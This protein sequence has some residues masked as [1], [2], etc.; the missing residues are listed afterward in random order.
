MPYDFDLFTVGGGSGGVA[1]SQYAGSLGARVAL[2]EE[3]QVG[4]TC[5][6]RGCV[7]KKLL[8]HAAQF[9]EAFEDAPGFGWDLSAPRLDWKRLQA[10]KDRELKRLESVYRQNLREV[11][12]Q[13]LEG[14]G[15]VVDAHTVEVAGRRYTARHLL[16]AT[17][18]RPSL[19]KV[20]GIE[21][22]LT[23]D[24]ALNLPELP[25]RL[26]IVG[27]GYI[28]VEFA[29]IFNTLGV[30]VSLVLEVERVLEGF[31]EDVRE[32][33][34]QAMRARGIELWTN[35]HLTGF[36]T[37][38][39]G[40]VRLRTRE[41]DA[42]EVDAVL[43][44][45]GREPQTRGLGLEEVGVRLS[46]KG[47]VKVDEHSRSSVE[48]LYAVGDVTD[49]LNLTPVAIAEGRAVVETL[50]GQGARTVEHETVASAVF[51]HPP[52]ATLGLTEAR[53]RERHGAVE[54][55]L[56]RFNPLSHALSGRQ[57]PAL[58]KLLVEPGSERVL[59]LHMVGPHAPEI[60][61]GLAVALRH[62]LTRSQLE[63]TVGLHPTLAEE[64]VSLP[65]KRS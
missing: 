39:T 61:Q 2:C 21:H 52:V 32:A 53:A 20:P 6:H 23:S 64:V 24:D 45:T 28:G 14:R 63:A 16:V 57:E 5:V 33:L 54:V 11:G 13:L 25:R 22:A 29:G 59:G 48:S 46:E 35:R 31:D 47:A 30:R 15:R 7:P 12:V 34:T 4:G 19:P 49:R 1:A 38:A 3:R 56:K 51:S 40:G 17:G 50:F 42:L 65:R 26:A 8:F 10:A 27:A 62:G 58:M 36:D 44:A 41:G 18:S 37:L 9:Q 55:Y 43:C 60:F